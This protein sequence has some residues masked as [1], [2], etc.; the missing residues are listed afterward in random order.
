[1][2]WIV[3]R[4]LAYSLTKPILKLKLAATEF[5]ANRELQ[6]VT[7]LLQ[8]A[9]NS[10]DELGELTTAYVKMTSTIQRYINEIE[11]L[12]TIGHEINTIGQDGLEGV[13]RKITDRA[14]ELIHA[15][16]CLVLLH[17]QQ[18]G[19]WVIEAASGTWHD[20]LRKSVMLWEE[21]PTCVKACE[22]GEVSAGEQLHFDHDPKFVRRH[23]IGN[24]MLAIPLLAQG[25]PMGVL[26]L[27]CEEARSSGEWNQRLATGMAQDAAV[28]I[29]N[30]KLVEAAEEK[31]KVLLKR[32]RHLEHQAEALAHDLKGPSDRVRQLATM[33]REDF[34]DR[35]DTKAQRWIGLLEFSSKEMVERVEGILNLARIGGKKLSLVAVDP[36]LV[37]HDV[38]KSYEEEIHR[39][40]AVV[41][42]ASSFP[43]VACHP[44]YLRQVFDNLISNSLKYTRPGTAPI[45]AI[46]SS[47]EGVKVCFSITDEGIGIP[48]DLRTK[49][50]QPFVRVGESPEPG[51]G[52]G[53]SIV[54][55][56]IELYEGEIWIEG[57][58]DKGCTI[59]LTLPWLDHELR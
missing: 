34:G 58:E 13:L 6:S 27:L 48:S 40:G 19:C 24:S 17:H 29:S 15:D 43:I 42:V 5:E 16:V 28:A 56:I 21:L 25:H 52:I 18:M 26:A 53:L 57:T 47:V 12:S 51:S 7:E 22:T 45:I 14:V 44:E 37:I 2:G 46:S 1:L 9:L 31:S 39:R 55:R 36:N 35:L 50:F 4:V 41:E 59:K 49:V 10:N 3:S 20:R 11:V 8:P 54:Q 33:L 30:A 23:L 32:L 38:I